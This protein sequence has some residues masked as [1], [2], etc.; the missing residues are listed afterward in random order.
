MGTVL[1]PGQSESYIQQPK[2]PKIKR[3][4]DKANQRDRAIR[5]IAD[6]LGVMKI[7]SSLVKT[8]HIIA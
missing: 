5:F 6:S 4:S 2:M 7:L 1:F 3:I 8:E